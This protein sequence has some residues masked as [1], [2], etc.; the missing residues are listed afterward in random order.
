MEEL[1][2]R[3][4]RRPGWD[5]YMWPGQAVQTPTGP[6]SRPAAMAGHRIAGY[7]GN[8]PGNSGEK[9]FQGLQHPVHPGVPGAGGVFLSEYPRCLTH[10]FVTAR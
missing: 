1:A 3:W 9:G 2:Q 7:E 10:I 6:L 4:T 5:A 8:A